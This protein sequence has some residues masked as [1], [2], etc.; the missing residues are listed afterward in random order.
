MVLFFLIG[1]V[2]SDLCI[3]LLTHI[4]YNKSYYDVSFYVTGS[5]DPDLC[6]L[7]IIFTD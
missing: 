1:N 4:V 7:L 3:V 2:D 5:I 6:V